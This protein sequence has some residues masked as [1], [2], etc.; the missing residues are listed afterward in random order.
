M[1]F[2]LVRLICAC[3]GGVHQ[4][5]SQQITWIAGDRITCI[6]GDLFT[7]NVSNIGSANCSFL[8]SVISLPWGLGKSPMLL[9]EYALVFVF[10]N[11]LI[12]PSLAVYTYFLF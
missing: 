5:S 7:C 4:K 12:Q 11:Y 8:P 10:P 6:A 2:Q 9:N 3:P 1:D